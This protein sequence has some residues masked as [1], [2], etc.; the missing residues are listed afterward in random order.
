MRSVKNPEPAGLHP[1]D[2]NTERDQQQLDRDRRGEGPSGSD[3]RKLLTHQERD[4]K[5]ETRRGES[6][7]RGDQGDWS[8]VAVLGADPS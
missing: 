4:R 7:Q 5:G 6:G 3:G 1:R 8:F 2:G